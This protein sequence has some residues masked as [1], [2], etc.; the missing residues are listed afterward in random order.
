[1]NKKTK[2][3]TIVFTDIASS[4][5]LYQRLGNTRAKKM[6]DA[7]MR[8]IGQTVVKYNGTIVKTIGDEMMSCFDTPDQAVTAAVEMNFRIDND[9][10]ASDPQYASLNLYTGIHHGPVIED[11][12][13]F[14]GDAV[15]IAAR[16]VKFAKQRQ[17]ITTSDLLNMLGDFPRENLKSMGN[18]R[19]KGIK[20]EIDVYE[21]V[22]EQDEMTMVMTHAPLR[23][24]LEITLELRHKDRVFRIDSGKPSLSIG[25]QDYNDLIIKDRVISRSHAVIEQRKQNFVLIDKSSNGT[26]VEAENGKTIKL[27]RDEILLDNKGKFSVGSSTFDDA[28][29]IRYKIVEKENWVYNKK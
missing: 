10:D 26:F 22:W 25:R 16:M 18:V 20:N 5:Q 11:K 1:M 9:F 21:V 3:K 24:Q 8:I 4:T 12:G 15:N 27:L 29:L 7:C 6:I 28:G 2:S 14:F 13:D 19:V 23:K 17:I